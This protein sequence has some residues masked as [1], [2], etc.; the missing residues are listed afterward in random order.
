MIIR[1]G[2]NISPK[3][4]EDYL[5]THPDVLDSQV[6][7]VPDDRLGEQVVVFIRLKENASTLTHA[8]LKAFCKGHLAHYKVPRFVRIVDEFPKT[9][10]GKIQKFKLRDSFVREKND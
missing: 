2:E 4:V 1:G 10:S 5:N 3:E 7:G 8:D 9:V 6:V